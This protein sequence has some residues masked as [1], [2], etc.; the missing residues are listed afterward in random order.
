MRLLVY[1]MLVNVN[2]MYYVHVC[3]QA[4]RA[5]SVGNSAIVNVCI[6]II[7]IPLPQKF[8]HMSFCKYVCCDKTFVTCLFISMLAVTKHLSQQ[9]F[10][11]MS[12]CKYVCCEKTKVLSHVFL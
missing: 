7:F 5:R 2:V 6:I 10:C 12:F 11:H 3:E 8:C 4:R 1:D 9:N